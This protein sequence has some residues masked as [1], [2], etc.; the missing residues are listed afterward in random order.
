MKRLH[1]NVGS[2]NAALEK[3]PE[4]LKAV[5]VHAAIYVLSRMVYDLM[6]I[7]AGQSVV[8]HERVSIESRASGDVLADFL[9]QYF[10][11]A[12]RNDS[13][14]YFSATLKDSHDSGLVMSASASNAALALRDVHV[15]CLA[16]D[17]GFV[18]FH[19]AAKLGTE[20][21]ILHGQPNPMQH[22]PCRLLGPLQVT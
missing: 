6:S 13:G 5:G 21:I 8:G 12:A 20:E 2:R 19:F 1:A 15:T 16:A 4:I 17:E 7:V 18:Y 11:L 9:L 3:R 22:E 10:A 14:A